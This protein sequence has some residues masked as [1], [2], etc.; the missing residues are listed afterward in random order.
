MVCIGDL[1]IAGKEQYNGIYKCG[2][3]FELSNE[4]P[5]SFTYKA[6]LQDWQ[7]ELLKGQSFVVARTTNSLGYEDVLENGFTVIQEALDILSIKGY[8]SICLDDPTKA[9]TSVFTRGESIISSHYNLLDFPMNLKLEI[10]TV[11]SFGNKIALQN[12]SEPVWNECFRYYRLSQSSHDLFEAYRNLFLSFEALLNF[13]CKKKNNEGEGNWLKRALTLVNKKVSLISSTP[14]G[15]EDPI[16]YIITS[17]YKN[18]RC[19]LQHAKFPNAQLPHAKLSFQDVQQA[20]AELVRIWRQIA[21]S[22]LNI[23]TGGGIITYIGFSKMM[24]GF[25]SSAVDFYITSD[26]TSPDESDIKTSPKNLACHKIH[27]TKYIGQVKPGVVRIL[28][29]ASSIENKTQHTIPIHRIGTVTDMGLFS[30]SYIKPGLIMSG[31]D[32]SE[33]IN[34]IRLINSA[35]PKIEFNT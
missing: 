31:V 4:S 20:Y 23:P 16:S 26:N 14:N 34:D 12:P 19:K 6:T 3:S 28:G 21:G 22:Y 32:K 1:F 5:V 8:G 33:Y 10:T 9:H 2:I 30:V 24:E 11:D 15:D 13:I 35:Q 25:F 29:S 27:K 18:I 7:V 17:Q